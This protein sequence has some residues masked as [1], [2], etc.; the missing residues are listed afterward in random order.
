[1]KNVWKF[2][3]IFIFASTYAFCVFALFPGKEVSDFLG[4]WTLDIEGGYVGWI[5]IR[6]EENYLDADILWKWG[7]VTPV[8]NIYFK[9]DSTLVLSRTFDIKVGN[10]E[11][12]HTITHRFIINIKDDILKGISIESNQD[13]KGV[14]KTKFTGRKLPPVPLAPDLNTI[15]LGKPVKLFNG[16]D[17]S[18]WEIIDPSLPNG[19]TVENGVLFNDPEQ[20]EGQPFIR[21]ASI[22]TTQKFEDF[23]LTF[24]GEDSGEK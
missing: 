24:R 8:A 4:Q 6:Q 2:C 18:G 5:D 17:L 12:Q 11:R 21:Y 14:V 9:D 23:N 20:K 13:G 22:K 16:V 15:Q 10:S 3:L 1:M 7:S 19:F